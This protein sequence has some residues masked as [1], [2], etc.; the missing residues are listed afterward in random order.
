MDTKEVSLFSTFHCKGI[1]WFPNSPET[2]I[3]G[4]LTWDGDRLLLDVIDVSGILPLFLEQ[5]GL[6]VSDEDSIML[7]QLED[8]R[9]CTLQ[10]VRNTSRP[11]LGIPE[12]SIYAHVAFLGTHFSSKDAI[13]FSSVI[14]EFTDLEKWMF[15]D[16]LFQHE[17]IREDGGA[18]GWRVDFKMPTGVYA[19]IPAIE[20]DVNFG[21]SASRSGGF[22]T[23]TLNVTPN[24][25]ILPGKPQHFDW[26]LKIIR[27]LRNWLSLLIGRLV[28]PSRIQSSTEQEP[29]ENI[30]VIQS[31]MGKRREESFHPTLV[32]IGLH[33]I[34]DEVEPLLQKWFD[35]SERIRD[36]FNLFFG[37][38]HADNM[39]VEFHYLSLIQAVEA[40]SRAATSS[41]YVLQDD[42]DKIRDELVR[43]IPQSTPNDLKSSLKNKIKYGN[44]FS[45]RK[46]LDRLL[47][48]LEVPTLDM[49]CQNREQYVERVVATRNYL[50][51]YTSELREQAW[52]QDKMLNACQSLTVLL[53]ILLFK[54]VGLSE[55]RIRE[56][57]TGHFDTS[58][59]IAHYR[60]KL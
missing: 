53:T 17:D 44:E 32:R 19:H 46:R 52:H 9:P 11:S 15:K 41:T 27:D 29:Y 12:P 48:S 36:V 42:Y 33:S 37:T 4:I 8:G 10:G 26:H 20:A 1:W 13:L 39:Y 47:K 56:V 3:P 50:T 25:S 51:H 40:Y 59:T 6:G 35:H 28:Q 60:Q 57:L 49:I 5:V 18:Y 58:Q 54:E 14:V 45:L 38:I 31:W 30:Q 43:A 22:T 2:K 16:W 34:R 23:L 7:G 24:V 21:C 55:E